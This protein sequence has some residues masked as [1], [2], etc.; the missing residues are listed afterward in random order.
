[1][2]KSRKGLNPKLRAM[3]LG[4][5]FHGCAVLD[6][7]R[8]MGTIRT[9]LETD[10]VWCDYHNNAERRLYR[11]FD[12]PEFE[13]RRILE[14]A[15]ELGVDPERTV[16]A[17]FD[18][19]RLCEIIEARKLDLLVV[20]TF[21]GLIP[22]RAIDMV[23]GNCFI[24]H[25]CFELPPNAEYLPEESRGARVMDRIVSTQKV[26][27]FMEIA[28]LRATAKFDAGPIVASTYAS[29]AI[30]FSG[31]EWGDEWLSRRVQRAQI[32]S[33]SFVG[34][35]VRYNLMRQMVS[36][37]DARAAGFTWAELLKRNY[38]KKEL[39]KCGY[40]G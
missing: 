19:D 1:M 24:C 8:E 6:S 30:A 36:V 11:H 17:P 13:Q 9:W 27:I 25:P 16:F 35:L 5:S 20:A 26:P 33:A 32:A 14:R 22:Q 31:H 37:K 34:G 15:G 39:K 10:D 23:N 28:L 2:P 12:D 38:P 3:F 7:M 40:N 29:T 18:G 21:G 4:G